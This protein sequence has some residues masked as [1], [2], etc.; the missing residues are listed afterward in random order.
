MLTKEKVQP[1]LARLAI[2]EEKLTPKEA[3]PMIVV[4]S[5][6]PSLAVC[7]AF[8]RIGEHTGIEFKWA[9]IGD[10][11]EDHLCDAA[12][13]LVFWVDIKTLAITHNQSHKFEG[14]K[15]ITPKRSSYVSSPLRTMTSLQGNDSYNEEKDNIW[16]AHA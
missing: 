12:D 4:A 6:M 14:S 2:I 13:K 11:P 9:A 10:K 7:L 8:A 1:V 3:L 5:E 15:S 16:S